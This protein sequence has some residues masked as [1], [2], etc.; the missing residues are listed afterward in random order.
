MAAVRAA[1]GNDNVGCGRATWSTSFGRTLECEA[2]AR[3]SFSPTITD[4]PSMTDPANCPTYRGISPLAGL[5]NLERAV[6]ADWSLE[7]SVSR[8]KRLHYLLRRLHEAF[9]SRI[10]AEPIYE[11]KTAYSFHAYL[12][13]EQVSLIRRRV[14]EMREPPLG[15][16][17]VPHPA[18]ERLMD[19]VTAAP[20]T[21]EW[22]TG[23]VQDRRRRTHRCL[24]TT[25]ERRPSFGRR[26][27]RSRRQAD[28]IRTFR[29]VFLWTRGN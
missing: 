1:R 12:C 6:Q 24:P 18:L 21:V 27:D 20:T 3:L 9:T 15:L 29:S 4:H 17:H 2:L 5:C 8:L 14:A 11:L 19:E 13:A 25:Q 16:D 26:A 28:G 23:G 7:E 22:L 10:T